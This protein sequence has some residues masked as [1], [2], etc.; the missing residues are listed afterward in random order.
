MTEQ[1]SARMPSVRMPSVSVVIA[2]RGRPEML[3]AAVRAVLAQD[4]AGPIDITVVYDRIEIDQLDDVVVPLHR[5]RLRTVANTRSP[6]LAGS[7]NTGMLSSDGELIA[8]CDDDDEWLPSKLDRQIALW[9]EDPDAVL[10]ATGIRIATSGRL[11]DR[12]PPERTEFADLINSRLT[13][14]HPSSF[15]VRRSDVSG[16]LGL[17]D[18][19][20]PSSYGE[21]YD[22]L[23]RAARVG[24]IRGVQ[25]PLVVVNW[26]RTSFFGGKWQGIV[27]GLTYL[28]NKHPEFAENPKG[29]ARIEGQIAFAWAALG[30]RFEAR[31]WASRTISHDRS[32][33]RAYAALII[34]ARLMP[35]GPLV[36]AVNRGG[37]GL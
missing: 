9:R 26:N 20:L 18:E 8:F 15:L 28:L 19:E 1:Q 37:R 30:R 5:R 29:A 17:V 33:L 4:Y 31:T 13:E 23:L 22:F 11:V 35:A 7:R 32:Q 24:H 25:D 6:G 10:I 27:D 36:R 12:L 21:D 2:T 3:R 34:A 14:L 16:P